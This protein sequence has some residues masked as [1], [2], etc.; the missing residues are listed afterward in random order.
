MRTLS[1]P[2]FNMGG[3]IKEGIMHGLRE[4]YRSG[5]RVGF[6]NGTPPINQSQL[7]Q[8][9]KNFL[10]KT[11]GTGGTG[12]A[13]GTIG[14]TGSKAANL[15]AKAKAWKIPTD[16]QAARG[17]WGGL[18]K[19]YSMAPKQGFLFRNPLSVLAA[20]AYFGG[21]PTPVDKKYGITSRWENIAPMFGDTTGI[22]E[23]KFKRNIEEGANPNNWWRYDAGKH[24]PR[25]E[26]PLY[27]P[28][29][30]SMWPWD[31][32]ATETG[33]PVKTLEENLAIKDYGPHTK[34]PAILTQSMK[35]KVASAA[36]DRQ[37][38]TI[39]DIMG[40]DKSKSTAVHRALVDASQIVTQAPGGD[41][42]DITKDIISPIIAATGKRLEK[43]AD[44]REAAGLMLAKG[45]IDKYVSEGKGGALKQNAKDL[46]A[47]GVFKT[48]KAA[49]DHLAKTQSITEKAITY[50][51]TMKKPYVDQEVVIKTMT[52]TYD[53]IPKVLVSEE[54]MEDIKK[55]DDY[56]S[57]I[58]VFEKIKVKDKLGVGYYVIGTSGFVVDTGGKTK[59]VL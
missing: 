3:P 48:E 50:A 2:M 13:T 30:V 9:I 33:P 42:L 49:M 31:K 55:E 18:K 36:K 52:D 23:K 7:I 4:P 41:E 26:N 28:D 46:V 16:V 1:R 34:G 8:Q 44:I 54:D 43:P 19:A 29:K 35:D 21:A 57:E 37:L 47:A 22:M 10:S 12:G 56:K 45:E 40:Y 5:T 58:D 15:L 51:G 39:L 24:G 27:D 17:I 59:Q 53:S 38:N 32:G 6:A 11:G 14:Q 25:K 20:G